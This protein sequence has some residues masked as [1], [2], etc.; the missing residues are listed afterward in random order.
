MLSCYRDVGTHNVRRVKGSFPDEVKV[1][2]ELE[3]LQRNSCGPWFSGDACQ[4]F[5]V[6]LDD[7][8]VK[9]KDST[10]RVPELISGGILSGRTSDL[11]VFLADSCGQADRIL[12]NLSLNLELL[13]NRHRRELREP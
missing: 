6:A 5:L 1:S 10:F 11:S 4:C 8:E 9:A 7:N 3:C 13:L 2:D 12:R